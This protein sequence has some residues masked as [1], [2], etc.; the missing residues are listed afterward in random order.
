MTSRPPTAIGRAIDL[1]YR[2]NRLALAIAAVAGVAGA[3]VGVVTASGWDVA[4]EAAVW[5]GASLAAW[6]TARELDHDDA[7]GAT[8]A[9]VLAP[10]AVWGLGR[11]AFFSIAALIMAARVALRST[12]LVPTILDQVGLVVLGV[13]AAGPTAGWVAAMV[14]ALAVARDGARPSDAAPWGRVFGFAIALAATARHM[15]WG[16]AFAIGDGSM[17]GAGIAG[18][19]AVVALVLGPRKAPEVPCDAIPTPPRSSD[20]FVARLLVAIGA[21]LGAVVAADPAVTAPAT[22]ALVGVAVASRVRPGR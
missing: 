18:A 14:L 6:V 15:V 11:P 21:A 7:R 8:V 9:A 2:S 12:G 3:I 17:L 10:L 16:D 5:S 4:I 20:A 13:L 19:I 1:S 22:A